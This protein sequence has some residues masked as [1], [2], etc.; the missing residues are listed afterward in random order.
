ML[1]VVQVV[2]LGRGEQDAF[3]PPRAQKLAQPACAA[4][5]EG[6]QDVGHGAAHVLDRLGALMDRAQDVDQHHLAVDAGK[7]VAK[8]GPDHP[9]LVGI[10]PAAEFSAKPRGLQVGRQGRKGQGGRS[11]QLSGDQEPAGRAVRPARVAR[12][13]QMRGIDVGQLLGL[14][15]GEAVIAG[16]RL[17]RGQEPVGAGAARDAVQH[18]GRPLRK[19]A[20]HQAQVQQPLAGIVDDVHMQ[21]A[22]AAQ[23]P[24]HAA[25]LQAQRQAQLADVTRAVGPVR[26]GAGQRG[27]V[28]FEVEAG[29]GVVGLGLQP[30]RLEPPVCGGAQRRHAPAF[31]EVR[32]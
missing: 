4:G 22:R 26:I 13:V 12:R 18:L 29:D 31:Q 5:A 20:F 8:E 9:R 21:V 2:G 14:R 10:E 11:R 24:E 6:R 17:Q 28:A 25:A 7:V 3:D 30:H 19:V 23:P 1:G 32:H 16:Q 15:F 27:Q